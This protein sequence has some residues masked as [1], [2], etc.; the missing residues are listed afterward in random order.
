MTSLPARLLCA[1]SA[2]IAFAFGS[3]T[4]TLSAQDQLAREI[5]FVR[6]LAKELK[7]IELAKA[8]ADRLAT[9]HRGAGD[10]DR[11]AQLSVE[12][13]YYGARSRNNRALQRTLFKETVEKSQE[14]IDRSSDGEVKVQAMTTLANATQDFG[15]FLIQELEIARNEN[16][17]QVPGIQEETVKVLKAGKDACAG[18]KSAL[19]SEIDDPQK[20]IN[21]GLMW[22]KGA[23]LTREQ[24]KA[25]KENRGVLVSRAIEDLEE[26]VLYFGEESALGLRGLFE[27]AQC[28]EVQ[29]DMD[30]AVLWYTDTIDQIIRSLQGAADGELELSPEM[31]GF[32]FGM[33]QEVYVRA[34]E[35]M[36]REG[37]AGTDKLFEDFRKNIAT[38]GEEG[39]DIFEVVSPTY[40]HL[41]LL[42]ESRY[43]AESGDATKVQ[44]ALA[45]T[46]RINDKHPADY[47]G[48]RAK[49][50][51]SEIL[52]LQSGLVSGALLFEVGK[53]DLQKRNYESAIQGLRGA[54]AA[55]TTKELTELGLE[56]HKML[57]DAYSR[58]DRLLESMIALD[59]GLRLY[60]VKGKDNATEPQPQADL[61]SDV[62]DTLDRLVGAHKRQT[63]Q[64]AYFNNMWEKYLEQAAKF[65]SG[66]A[67]KLAY[68]TGSAL[69][70]TQ[71]YKE[72]AAEF[73]KITKDYLKYE[74]AVV[75]LARAQTL[76]GDFE[77]GRKTVADYRKYVADNVLS[78]RD[79]G[80]Q[81]I[82][83]VALA[84]ASYNDVQMAYYE[85]RGNENFNLKRNLKNYP[86]AIDAIK[87]FMT[88]YAD[89]GKIY[90]P[91]VLAY[92]G[93]L[94]VDTG[95]M[96]EAEQAYTQLK[97]QDLAK[98]SRLA[99]EIFQEYQAQV[100][101]QIAEV[102]KAYASKKTDKE[103]VAAKQAVTEVRRK[104]V[105]LGTDY[106]N[107]SP[108]PQLAILVNTMLNWSELKEWQRVAEV[109]DK[110][111]KIYGET[112]AENEQRVVDLIVRPMVGEALLQRR[113]F[114]KA[115]DM[116]KAAEAANPT[117]WELKRQ[118]ARALGGWFE[119]NNRGAA[120]REPG[121]DRPVEAYMKYYGD[122]TDS[123]R[124]YM[125]RD[126]VKKFSYEWY[127]FM[128]EAYWFA[129][130]AGTKDSKYKEIADTFYRKA[131]S[132]DDFA[133]LRRF[134]AKGEELTNYFKT[135]K[136]R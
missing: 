74:Q 90:V 84:A 9:E 40:G 88:N 65:S 105:S 102:D 48:V 13:A 23:V 136:I 124:I 117:Q 61:S 89:D 22:M 38:Y 122:P 71:K 31:A 81:T 130:Q 15:Q 29:G 106:I 113:E 17:D 80:R 96:A 49:A 26:M 37:H 114:T 47:I 11:I 78:A 116:L 10:Q 95:A 36:A 18:V 53:G 66:G 33:M 68:K 109:A 92:L 63:K 52:A 125:Q 72:A 94:H 8:E 121:L 44:E 91:Q 103:I 111:L 54:I 100:K 79:S 99:S 75:R 21:Y 55:M 24:A 57:G 132:T 77:A 133:S 39:L 108:R 83:K 2:T 129:K 43:K 85:A 20:K 34:G 107:S 67:N 51:L 128:W 46:Q 6:S 50:V 62:A 1:T 69:F 16:P 59:T 118:I 41:M 28:Y 120:V 45:M 35:T 5:D 104:L 119:F 25:D 19:E 60:G 12:V 123:Y 32:L 98:S 97:S 70:N 42:A 135:N 58:S 64:D 112:K 73:A 14:L 134:G 56:A 30:E 110:T 7:F 127:Q 115:L 4:S 3:L 131:R 101:S 76:S 87:Q 82:R 27:I 126:E 93:R 86:A